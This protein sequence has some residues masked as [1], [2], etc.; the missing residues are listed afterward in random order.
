MNRDHSETGVRI[1]HIPTGVCV[2]VCALHHCVHTGIV[3]ERN[4]ERYSF[5]NEQQAL[6]QLRTLLYQR[7]HMQKLQSEQMQRKLQV[8]ATNPLA[9]AHLV[10]LEHENDRRK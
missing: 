6:Q 8:C 10:R 7:E 2:C 5:E 9:G 4:K 1:V 3:V